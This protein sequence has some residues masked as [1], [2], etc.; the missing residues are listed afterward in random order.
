MRQEAGRRE[1]KN[2]VILEGKCK[3]CSECKD[4]ERDPIPYNDIYFGVCKV[5]GKIKY[6]FHICDFDK[7]LIL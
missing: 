7:S 6:E 4:W 5:D 2:V 3:T 1:G